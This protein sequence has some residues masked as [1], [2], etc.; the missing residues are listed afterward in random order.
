MPPR[1]I[2]SSRATSIAQG[3]TEAAELEQIGARKDVA[4]IAGERF[5]LFPV[6]AN[7]ERGGQLRHGVPKVGEHTREIL[8]DLDAAV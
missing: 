7:G 4:S 5:A 8:V 1:R 6:H 3:S 2:S